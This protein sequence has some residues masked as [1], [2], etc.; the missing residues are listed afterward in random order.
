GDLNNDGTIVA[1]IRAYDVRSDVKDNNKRLLDF[2]TR[3]GTLVVQYIQSV[4]AFNV[5]KFTPYPATASTKRVTV[6][7]APVQIL[8][9]G[10][11]VFHYPNEI[12]PSDFNVW[13]RERGVD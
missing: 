8:A 3:G 10:D 9:P 6:E 13:V 2:G 1:G 11:S 12:K 4:G 7:E 5:G